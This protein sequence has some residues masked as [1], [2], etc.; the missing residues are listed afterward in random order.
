MICDASSFLLSSIDIPAKSQIVEASEKVPCSLYFSSSICPQCGMFSA[1]TTFRDLE[2][3]L[4]GL[5]LLLVSRRS[6]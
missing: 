5:D 4:K 3:P 6:D 2:P 1:G